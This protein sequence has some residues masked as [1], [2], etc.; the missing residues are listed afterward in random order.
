MTEEITHSRAWEQ[1]SPRA[2]VQ[3]VDVDMNEDNKEEGWHLDAEEDEIKDEIEDVMDVEEII[4]EW[5]MY[6]FFY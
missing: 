3:N 5:Q 1:R 2:P 6:V 4:K